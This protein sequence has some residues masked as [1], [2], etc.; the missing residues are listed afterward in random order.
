MQGKFISTV[1]SLLSQL[2]PRRGVLAPNWQCVVKSMLLRDLPNNS[3][4]DE[5]ED[6]EVDEEDDEGSKG[7]E[8][9]INEP[10][11]QAPLQTPNNNRSRSIGSIKYDATS[12]IMVSV[13]P[14]M[15]NDEAIKILTANRYHSIRELKLKH[16]TLAI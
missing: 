14:N 3:S 11:T 6:D 10:S 9:S 12:G 2:A 16:K 4:D 15:S 13:N 1:N 7:C 8:E 5:E